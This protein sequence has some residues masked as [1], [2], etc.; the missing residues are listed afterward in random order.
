[1]KKQVLL[2]MN[3]TGTSSRMELPANLEKSINVIDIVPGQD[4]EK[5]I[6]LNKPG[7]IC[8]D[9]DCPFVQG[10]SLLRSIKQKFPSIPIL[11]LTEHHS[12]SL[13]L[14][15][16]RSRVWD[17][18]VKPVNDKSLASI[19]LQVEALG[20]V[21]VNRE[22][23]KLVLPRSL[24]QGCENDTSSE[25]GRDKTKNAIE[26]A[27]FYLNNNL[28]KKIIAKEVA[29]HCGMS[30]FHF[31]RSFKQVCGVTFSDYLLERRIT[32]AK[33]LIYDHNVSITSV[34]YDVGFRDLSYFSRV[35][36][37]YHGMTP[38]EYRKYCNNKRYIKNDHA[39]PRQAGARIVNEEGVSLLHI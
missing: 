22:N 19:L 23:R 10:L 5:T 29:S 1:M 4:V 9:F 15:A 17:Y 13:V 30:P 6:S 28:S 21:N 24:V 33:E 34:C 39:R 3:L 2:R 18:F 31:S 11:M 8:F 20:D 12:E 25:N 36:K 37:R 26:K 14:W 32:K 16:L 27:I 38:S 35:F 7:I